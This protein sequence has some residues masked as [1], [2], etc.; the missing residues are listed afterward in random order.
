ME[1]YIL[2]VRAKDAKPYA[3]LVIDFF[4]HQDVDCITYKQKLRQNHRAN[5]LRELESMVENAKA[6]IVFAS[7]KILDDPHAMRLMNY[8][9]LRDN[10]VGVIPTVD[11]LPQNRRLDDLP[12]AFFSGLLLTGTPDPAVFAKE[13]LDALKRANL[14]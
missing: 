6:V 9:F 12:Y 7:P 1:G 8:A 10:I 2:F 5:I 14:I 3:D 11:V 13:L 4:R